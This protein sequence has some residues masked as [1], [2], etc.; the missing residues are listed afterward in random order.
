[1]ISKARIQTSVSKTFLVVALVSLSMIGSITPATAQTSTANPGKLLPDGYTR[2]PDGLEYK[3]ITHGDGK[4]KPVLSD[5]MELHISYAVGDSMIFDSRKMNN[6][7]CVPIP[8]ATPRGVGDPV[9]VF[10]QMVAGDSAV[11]RFPVDSLKKVGQTY[12]WNKAGDMV[13]YKIKM[14]SVKTEAEF[15]KEEAEKA[16]VQNGIDDK[17]LQA[18]F[19]EKGIKPAK[20]ASG[21]YYTIAKEGSG[22]KIK[23]GQLVG[24]NYT[25]KFL[26]GKKFDSNTDT[27]FHH[28]QI[29]SLEVGK[30]KVIKGW[31]EGLQLLKY[32]SKATL[33]IPSALA[34]GTT[35]RPG[36]PANSILVFDVEL[37]DIPDHAKIDDKIIKD[38][39]T[40]NNIQATKTASGLYY[41]I[42]KKG[43]GENAKP[44]KKV[45]MNYTGQTLDGIIFDS[46]V[47]PHFNH[48]QPFSFALG[49]G[50]VIRG[51]DEGVQ[52][53]N[54][55]SKATFYIPSGLAYGEQGAGG[56]IGPNTVLSFDVELVQID[57]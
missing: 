26:D 46:N 33:Y 53:L 56:A 27:A 19:K 5:H 15:N 42:T 41:V 3:I 18:Y 51:W 34:Y 6:N 30:G 40:K 21:L 44:G 24:V 36:L 50:Q 28:M 35:E 22:E 54:L 57:N 52:L 7:K 29:F 25:G 38:Y 11:G 47:D 8:M 55:G 10:T 12:P 4:K 9:A 13:I 16:A 45:T 43:L 1:M 32:G 31:D 48:V 2:L 23:A 49:M 20:T 14:V 39:I 37:I 17:A